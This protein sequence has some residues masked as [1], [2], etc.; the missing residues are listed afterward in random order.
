MF[1]QSVAEGP[2]RRKPVASPIV[3]MLNSCEEN[4]IDFGCEGDAGY[5]HPSS[6]NVT[7][8]FQHTPQYLRTLCRSTTLVL[9]PVDVRYLRTPHDSPHHTYGMLLGMLSV[10]RPQFRACKGFDWVRARLFSVERA[11]ERQ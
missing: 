9:V 2:T 8:V 10:W 7:P 5:L 4:G 1:G 6:H 11:G 3:V